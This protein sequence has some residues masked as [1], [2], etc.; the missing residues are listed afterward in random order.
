[1][2]NTNGFN[3]IVYCAF[4]NIVIIN[5]LNVDA[6]VIVVGFDVRFT[7]IDPFDFGFIVS[8]TFDVGPFIIRTSCCCHFGMSLRCLWHHFCSLKRALQWHI[9]VIRLLI[10]SC[11]IWFLFHM[12]Y[13]PRTH[14]R[15]DAW[16]TAHQIHF[17]DFFIPT[18]KHTGL[19]AQECDDEAR[20]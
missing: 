9:S 5:R 20:L 16:L 12:E 19:S 14:F 2:F 13:Y 3:N 17:D 10:P 7:V 11:N 1:M 4:I 18:D 8:G 6:V 15:F